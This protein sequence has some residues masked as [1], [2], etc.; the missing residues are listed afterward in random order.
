MK[1]VDSKQEMKAGYEIQ[2]EID[3]QKCHGHIDGIVNIF[4]EKDKLVSVDCTG[5]VIVWMWNYINYNILKM[6][7]LIKYE[8]IV[9]FS[10]E[11]C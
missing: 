1:E 5:K 8:L 3:H 7:K 10:I 4:K 6:L 9:S 11:G 2:K